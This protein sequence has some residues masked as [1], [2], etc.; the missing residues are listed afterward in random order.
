MPVYTA[1]YNRNPD[2]PA[3]K[4][5][6]DC[7]GLGA[8]SDPGMIEG[9][10]ERSRPHAPVRTDGNDIGIVTQ[11]CKIS[12]GDRD[13]LGPERRERTLGNC[14]GTMP[15]TCTVADRAAV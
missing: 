10:A 11:N 7:G 13:D 2:A 5:E 6:I 9:T 4:P 3:V 12:A 15:F 14:A 8:G 1:I